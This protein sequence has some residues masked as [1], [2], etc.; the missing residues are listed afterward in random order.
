MSESPIQIDEENKIKLKPELMV[1][2][3]MYPIVIDNS[4]FL[5]YK[6]ENE[7]INCYEVVDKE[8][9]QKAKENPEKILDILEEHGK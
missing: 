2:E 9:V 6:D 1:V 7:M 4:I 5:F 3:K 8:I